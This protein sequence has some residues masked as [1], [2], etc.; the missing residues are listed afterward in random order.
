MGLGALKKLSLQDVKN[1]AAVLK[2]APNKRM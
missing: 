2:A 1:M